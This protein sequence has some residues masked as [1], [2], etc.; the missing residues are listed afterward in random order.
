MMVTQYSLLHSISICNKANDLSQ[1]Q[2]SEDEMSKKQKVVATDL[3]IGELTVDQFHEIAVAGGE[4]GKLVFGN[5]Q[6]RVLEHLPEE[7]I[8]ELNFGEGTFTRCEPDV[9]P[10]ELH[11]YAFKWIATADREDCGT[12]VLLP[13]SPDA[14]NN[15]REGYTRNLMAKYE[16]SRDEASTLYT[17]L[18]RTRYGHE[19]DVIAYVMET[20]E[21]HKDAWDW[22]PGVGKGVWAW[23]EKW[24]M[25]DTDLTAPRLNACYLIVTNW[26]EL[27]ASPKRRQIGRRFRRRQDEDQQNNGNGN[28][29]AE[30]GKD[31]GAEGVGETAAA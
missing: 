19:D 11:G 3:A 23:F 26:K 1:S 10:K 21:A 16:M 8:K 6:G 24:N 27:M 2:R 18:R 12:I 9:F 14:S 17:V 22:F 31:A 28:G 4:V 7:K 5:V 29:A 20:H 25:P 15:L 13:R 30:T